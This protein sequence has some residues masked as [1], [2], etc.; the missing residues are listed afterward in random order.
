[1]DFFITINQ[2]FSIIK[3]R[4]ANLIALTVKNTNQTLS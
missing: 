4:I 2:D 3:A 1:L